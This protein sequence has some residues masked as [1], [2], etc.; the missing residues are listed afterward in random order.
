MGSYATLT[1]G[2]CSHVIKLIARAVTNVNKENCCIKR[3]VPEFV[4]QLY[5]EEMAHI[6][7]K[8]SGCSITC[9][10]GETCFKLCPIHLEDTWFL[11]HL[12]IYSKIFPCFF[13]CFT[14][15]KLACVE[16]SDEFW[17]YE[18]QV[19]LEAF[20]SN[21]FYSL[22]LKQSLSV[23]TRLGQLTAE[24]RNHSF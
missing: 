21:T 23:T 24:V 18:H 4:V 9:A 15:W 13:L 7:L 6:S 5:K 1:L 20:S 19:D 14:M 22:L 8:L 2:W 17:D 10:S 3:Q 12:K 11:A 16:C